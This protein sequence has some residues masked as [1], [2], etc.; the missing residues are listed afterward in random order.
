[1]N[2]SG[3]A[4]ESCRLCH[5][6][7]AGIFSELSDQDLELL[8]QSK[9]KNRYK[10]KQIIFYE[11]N[12]IVGLYCIQSG[13]VKLYKTSEK[14]KQQILKIAQAGHVLG[15]SAL[16][17]DTPHMATA[18]AIED[19]EI[20][21]LDKNRF[22]SILQANP[23]VALKVLGQLSRDLNRSEGQVLD[24]AYKS[25]RVRFA[26]FL[27]TLKQSFGVYDN[28]VYRLQII[29]TREEL[30]Q[31]VGVTTETAVR[32]LSEFRAEGLIEIEKKSIT[33]L[34]SKKLIEFTEAGY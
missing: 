9:I 8:K 10:R 26:E 22:L 21:F 19:S 2:C 33:L 27:L 30:A 7:E 16:F 25:A 28:G 17:A 32:L 23:S 11:N 12:P 34:D 1:M 5:S 6:F 13:K 31:A 14:G 4:S 3:K 15:H 24:L 29:L 18:E 20:C